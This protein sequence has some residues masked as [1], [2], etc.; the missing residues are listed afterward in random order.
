MRRSGLF[1][2]AEERTEAR[3]REER[4]EL[5]S[6]AFTAS[7][8]YHLSQ[9]LGGAFPEGW[10]SRGVVPLLGAQRVEGVTYVPL[11]ALRVNPVSPRSF[12]APDRIEEIAL[13]IERDGLYAPL[14]VRGDG[15]GHYLL[16]DGHYRYQALK[17]LAERYG[18][19]DLQVPVSRLGGNFA[20]NLV[21]QIHLMVSMNSQ[22]PLSHLER[23]LGLVSALAQG[24]VE[25]AHL[26]AVLAEV[27]SARFHKREEIFGSHAIFL[28]VLKLYGLSS[29]ALAYYVRVFMEMPELY[30]LA[31]EKKIPE[32][33]FRLLASPQVRN[34]PLFPQYL[35][36]VRLGITPVQA[37]EQR[38][39]RETAPPPPS[40]EER[41]FALLR[42]ALKTVKDPVRLE[43]LLEML[44]ERALETGGK[45]ALP[46]EQASPPVFH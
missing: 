40:P 43:Q 22:A 14:V 13:S 29:Q 27:N 1:A 16:I 20:N 4:Q 6:E 38:I 12:Y 9:M 30:A 2:L 10:V 32:R 19:P 46:A 24:G 36:E 7:L 41:A 33:L 37:L 25:M 31:L 44:K 28:Q 18:K 42:R 15:Q 39:R 5:P 34:H 17:R 8:H 45:E 26:K 23:A 11:S 35:E 3:E 21:R